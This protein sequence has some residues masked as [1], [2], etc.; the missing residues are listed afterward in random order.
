MIKTFCHRCGAEMAPYAI[1]PNIDSGEGASY[2][3]CKVCMTGIVGFILCT[4]EENKIHGTIPCK[5]CEG[6]GFVYDEA[7]S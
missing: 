1:T 6:R 3:I 2:H 4:H 5:K 7:K